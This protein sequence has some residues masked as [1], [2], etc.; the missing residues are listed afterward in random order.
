MVE[1]APKTVL[2]IHD[3]SCLGRAGLSAVVPVLAV[4][5]VQAIA[6]PTAVLSSHTG[7]LGTPAAMQSDDYGAAALEQ[8]QE[9]GLGFDAIYSGY[10]SRPEQA[11]LVEKAHEYWPEAFLLVDPVL[12][13]GGR[14]YSGVT[15]A[16]V[17]AMRHLCSLADLAVPN[18]TEAAFLLGRSVEM[19]ADQAGAIALA[20]AVK[21]ATG[22]KA[23]VVTGIDIGRYVFCA[24]AARDNFAV[25]RL[26]IE[27]SYPGTGD[28][29]ASVLLSRLCI[30]NALSAAVDA[31]AAFVAEC[32]SATPADADSRLG[33]WFEPRLW[34]LAAR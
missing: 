6:L 34:Q 12:G 3:L 14:L 13:D 16:T 25:R 23:A 19:P 26:R 20:G 4:S 9:L 24:G 2:C 28:L 21:D 5:G 31:A 15:D 1:K 18:L 8:Y 33:V 22:A 11:R 27:R 32:I 17:S 10:L 30:G 29:F 7:G